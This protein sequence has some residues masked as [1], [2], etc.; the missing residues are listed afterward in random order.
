[1]TVAGEHEPWEQGTVGARGAPA[2][3]TEIGL[4]GGDVLIYVDEHGTTPLRRIIR[5]LD[6]PAPLVFMAV[7]ALVR[8]GL[9]RAIRHDLEMIVEA[10]AGQETHAPTADVR[11]G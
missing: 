4:I 1:M 2:V 9:V 7:G 3:M 8:A 11:G 10:R 6:W 5:D